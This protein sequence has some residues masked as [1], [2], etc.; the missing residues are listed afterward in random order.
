MSREVAR[1]RKRKIQRKIIGQIRERH[2]INNGWGATRHAKNSPED[3]E[4]VADGAPARA[5]LSAAQ[6]HGQATTKRGGVC[7]AVSPLERVN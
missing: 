5:V 3:R 6:T 1:E 4:L 2:A 7:E